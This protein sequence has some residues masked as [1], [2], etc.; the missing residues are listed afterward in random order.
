[1]RR[2]SVKP[3]VLLRPSDRGAATYIAPNCSD[4]T[5]RLPFVKG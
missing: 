4:S 2:S 5:E 3:L 1:M